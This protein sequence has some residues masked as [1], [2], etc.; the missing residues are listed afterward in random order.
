MQLWH[1]RFSHIKIKDKINISEKFYFV[2]NICGLYK[3]GV[4][5]YVMSCANNGIL[6]FF[7]PFINLSDFQHDEK[8]QM[9]CLIGIWQNKFSYQTNLKQERKENG[10]NRDQ[11][12]KRK[13]RRRRRYGAVQCTS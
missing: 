11:D 3:L 2:V 9:F 6:F 7:S 4:I 8:L 5:L 12:R 13:K 10:Q 1:L